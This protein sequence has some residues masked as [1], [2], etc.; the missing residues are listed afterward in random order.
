MPRSS[1]GGHFVLVVC[2][3]AAVSAAACSRNTPSSPTA[4][5]ASA[6]EAAIANGGPGLPLIPVVGS[7]GG[8]FNLVHTETDRLGSGDSQLTISVH[9]VPPNTVLYLLRA[10]DLG[11][12]G[13]QQ[14]DGVC[15]RAAAGLFGQ[16]PLPGGGN[17]TLETSPGGTGE[18]HVHFFG[19]GEG[20]RLDSVWRLVD[21]VPP[22]VPTVDLR[23]PCFTF[24]VK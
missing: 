2:T 7:G 20:N 1:S 4:P 13:G 6:A 14:A 23:T 3:V 18:M 5:G 15:Q 11:L 24:T 21:A 12:P 16:V 19:P 22:A 9:G 17:A 8:R 10:G